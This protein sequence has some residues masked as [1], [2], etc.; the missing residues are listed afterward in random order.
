MLYIP[1]C[2]AE[3]FELEFVLGIGI[4]KET[5]KKPQDEK[6]PD[7]FMVSCVLV[8]HI[9][10]VLRCSEIFLVISLEFHKEN[11]KKKRCAGNGACLN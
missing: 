6:L 3:K 10:H 11:M 7:I 4:G 5:E 2:P 1:A 8:L 9:R